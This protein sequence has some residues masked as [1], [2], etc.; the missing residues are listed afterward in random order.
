MPVGRTSHGWPTSKEHTA[1]LSGVF[2][3]T[4]LSQLLELRQSFVQRPNAAFESYSNANQLPAVAKPVVAGAPSQ[5]SPT[6][7][8]SSVSEERL[9]AALRDA[10]ACGIALHERSLS[11]WS[12][13][14][15]RCWPLTWASPWHRRDGYRPIARAISRSWSRFLIVS[16]L[17]RCVLPLTRASSTLASPRLLK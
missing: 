12:D 5:S 1:I 2:D 13:V 15:G 7:R 4:W 10:C 11:F 16:R 14:S 3:D 8:R 9:P 17:S 6:G